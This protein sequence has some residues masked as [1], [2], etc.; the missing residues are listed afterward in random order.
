MNILDQIRKARDGMITA[1]AALSD[2]VLLASAHH[3]ALDEAANRIH[4]A[5]RPMRDE[6]EEP[7]TIDWKRWWGVP[8]NA[9]SPASGETVGPNGWDER[10]RRIESLLNGRNPDAMLEQLGRIEALL[11]RIA[12]AVEPKQVNVTM[13]FPGLKVPE[14]AA[15][16]GNTS[17]WWSSASLA[18][19][20]IEVFGGMK[21]AEITDEL[22]QHVDAA[23]ELLKQI[24][25]ID[26][27]PENLAALDDAMTTLRVSDEQKLQ[28]MQAIYE[29]AR[30]G[31]L[32]I[33]RPVIV[34]PKAGELWSTPFKVQVICT[35]ETA[36]GPRGDEC[37]V[38][39]DPATKGKSYALFQLH[40]K[41]GHNPGWRCIGAAPMGWELT[42]TDATSVAPPEAMRV[43]TDGV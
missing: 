25:S 16:W 3:R 18:G 26:P 8:T 28:A 17:K 6:P 9:S 5:T 38:M 4:N 29:R 37:L 11:E 36:P 41:D 24:D 19:M 40:T 23:I 39:R 7:D 27:T 10:L 22:S 35:G 30:Q 42:L 31:T 21:G 33:V 12:M 34:R 15:S 13:G 43:K 2:G 32:T 20:A 14:G 1:F